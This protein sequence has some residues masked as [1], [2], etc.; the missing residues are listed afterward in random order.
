MLRQNKPI[1]DFIDEGF[2][3]SKYTYKQTTQE[4]NTEQNV[5]KNIGVMFFE[6]FF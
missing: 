3:M 4:Y 2:K 1:F 5:N 6:K